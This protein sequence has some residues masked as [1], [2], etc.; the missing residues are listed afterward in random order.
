M[1]VFKFGGASVKDAEGIRNVGRILQMFENENIVIIVSAMGK[2][3]NALEQIAELAFNEKDFDDALNILIQ[4]HQQ[5]ISALQ[6]DFNIEHYKQ[7]IQTQLSQ[8]KQFSYPK[9]YDQVV[10]IGE[11]ISSAILSSYLNH[12]AINNTWLDVRTVI[13][14]DET[15]REGIVDWDKTNVSCTTI[16]PALLEKGHVVTQGFIGG[17]SSGL[18]TTLGREGSDFTGAVF[19]NCLNAE[20]LWIWKDVPGVL[21]ADP[22]EFPYKTQLHELTYYEA[23]EMTYY[24][25]QVIH[26]K[27]IKPLQNK[28]IPLYVRSFINPE[29]AGTRIYADDSDKTYPPIIV[30]KKNQLLMSV[31]ANDFS[32]IAE[33]NLSNI[34]NLFADYKVK[35]NM[36]QTAALSFSAVVDNNP[37]TLNPLFEKLAE[38]YEILT[39]DNLQ[40][41]TI[42]HYTGEIIEELTKGKEILL[43]QRSR[44]T[45]QFLISD[46]RRGDSK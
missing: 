25:A 44:Q 12:A 20:G 15:W 16:L 23:V 45:I 30:L 8:S 22:K 32:F 10:S 18:V 46:Q 9:F 34:Y 29:A 17:T 1:K 4:N 28:Q 40:L 43:E 11:I 19:S 31:K 13:H 38:E 35:A 6:I 42:R 24:G 21:T 33:N 27:T 14:T 37:Y 2:T 3:T 41:L 39:N 5:I 26:P 36:I 7:L